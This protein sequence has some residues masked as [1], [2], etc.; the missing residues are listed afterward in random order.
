M[1][2]NPRIYA[3]DKFILQSEYRQA[4]ENSNMVSDLSVNNDGKNTIHIYLQKSKV[5]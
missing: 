1:I 4:F 2:F 5:V 3:D